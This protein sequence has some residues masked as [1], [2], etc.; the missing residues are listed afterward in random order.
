MK[1]DIHDRV[2]ALE[3]EMRG[4]RAEL[5]QQE[6]RLTGRV[7]QMGI[8]MR[9]MIRNLP[10]LRSEQPADAGADVTRARVIDYRGCPTDHRYQCAIHGPNC[11]N[12][13]KE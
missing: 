5:R 13:P 11:P 4:V 2:S 1:D 3:E 8:R 9:E 12:R 10:G 7:E 6:V